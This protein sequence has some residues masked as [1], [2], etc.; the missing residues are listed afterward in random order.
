MSGLCERKGSDVNRVAWSKTPHLTQTPYGNWMLFDEAEWEYSVGHSCSGGSP[1]D[2][3]NFV[4]Q[5]PLVLSVNQDNVT[6][7]QIWV[8]GIPAVYLLR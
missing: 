7:V 6:P 5:C 2:A 1:A 3:R 8:S 4:L